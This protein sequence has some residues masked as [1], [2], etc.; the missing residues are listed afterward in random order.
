MEDRRISR[1][2]FLRNTTASAVGAFIL[3]AS[4]TARA[5]DNRRI[6]APSTLITIGHIGVGGQGSG[7]LSGFLEVEGSRSVAVCDAFKSRR[8]AAAAAVNQKYAGKKKSG[9]YKGCASYEDFRDLL[10]DPGIDAVVIATPDHWHV[11]IALEA[12]RA[13]KDFYVEK[14]LGVSIAQNKALRSSV[15]RYGNIFQY[16]TQQRCFNTH[17]ALACELVRNGYLG[18][19]REIHVEAPPGSGGGSLEPVPVPEGFNYN[20]WLGPAP[21]RPYTRD[22]CTNSGTYHIYDNSLGFIAGWGAHPLDVMH[23]GYPQIPIEYE[24]TGVIPRTGLF[25][26]V[27]N[28]NVR[29]RFADGTAFTFKDGPDKTT[30]VGDEGWVAAS[31]GGIDAHP[32]SLLNVVIKPDE[33]HLLQNINHYQDFVNCVASRRPTSSPIDSAVQSDFVSHLSDIAIRTGRKIRWDPVREEIMGDAMATAMQGRPM[34]APWA[35]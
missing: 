4:T 1:R 22:R 10:G 3:P 27:T 11:P 16:G 19:I 18:K 25:N 34:R 33:I 29:G 24:G 26:T 9:Q 2:A 23:W 35:I 28:W 15:H 31:R 14:P 30:F 7:L 5:N 13:G 21:E 20:L 12:A 6:P 8:E 17:C 32:K